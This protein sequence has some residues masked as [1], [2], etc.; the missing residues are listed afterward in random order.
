MAEQRRFVEINIS[1]IPVA[2]IGGF[3]LVAIAA[4][5]A[6]VLPQTWLPLAVGAVG[7]ALLGVAVILA[8]RRRPLP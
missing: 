2:G 8:R 7:G 5:M 6:Y 1:D 4:I 3:G